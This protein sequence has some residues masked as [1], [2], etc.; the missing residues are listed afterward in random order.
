MLID[1]EL[2]PRM[3]DEFCI[4]FERIILRQGIH[5]T[6]RAQ[7]RTSIKLLLK[8]EIFKLAGNKNSF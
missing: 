5:H 2:V 1:A 3:P 7:L 6:I 8:N 4:F